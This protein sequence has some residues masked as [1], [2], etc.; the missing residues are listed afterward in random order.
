[1]TLSERRIRCAVVRTGT[2]EEAGRET[3][4]RVTMNFFLEKALFL[5]LQ[6]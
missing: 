3:A 5:P 2:P 4:E 6:Q 1:M